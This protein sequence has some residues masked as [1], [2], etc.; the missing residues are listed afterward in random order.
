MTCKIKRIVLVL[1]LVAAIVP[2]VLL[3]VSGY[4]ETLR[5]VFMADSRGETLHDPVN[6]PVLNAIIGQIAALSPKPSFVIFGGDMSYRGYIGSSY[7]FQAWKDLFAPLTGSGVALYTAVGNHE[8]YHEHSALGFMLENQQEFQKVFSENPANGPAG[9]EHLAYSFTSPGGDSFFAVLDPYYL[10]SDVIPKTLGGNIDPTQMSWLTAQVAQTKATHKF[11]FIHTPYYYISNDPD[12]LSDANESFTGLWAFL[13]TNKFDFYACGHSHLFSRKTIDSTVPPNPQTTPPTPAWQNN[14]VQLLN[15]TSGAGPSTGTIDPNIKTSWNVH[16]D[17]K[18]YYFSVVDINGN[19]VSVTSYSGYTGDYTAFDSFTIVTAIPKFIISQDRGTIGT[20]FSITGSG[21][22]TRKGRVFVGT[23]SSK[24]VQWADDSIQ[25]QLTRTLPAGAYDVTIKPQTKG[26]S[27]ITISDGFTVEAPRIDSI[28]PP[29]GSIGDEITV[30]GLFFGMTKGG[31]TL[32][33]KSCR[34]SKWTMDSET[35]ESEI[36]F[37]V[38]RGLSTGTKELKVTNG[39][40]ADTAVI[41]VGASYT[42]GDWLIIDHPDGVG[43]FPR[44]VAGDRVVGY[45]E[46]AT[47]GDHGFVYDGKTWTDLDYPGA[48]DTVAS[49]ISGK[50]IVGFYHTDPAAQ[51]WHGFVYDGKNWTSLDYPGAVST[52]AFGIEGHTIVGYYWDGSAD[53]GFMYDGKTWTTLDHPGAQ[54]TFVSAV[55]HSTMVGDYVHN[56]WFHGYL[57][58]GVNWAALDAPGATDTYAHGIAGD[59]V[60]GSFW[61]ALSRT[62]G[63]LYNRA[64]ATWT[65]L[66]FPG[67]DDTDL[68]GTDGESIVGYIRVDEDWHGVLYTLAPDHAHHSAKGEG[69]VVGTTPA[70]GYGVILHTTNGGHRWG[71]QGSTNDVPNVS[72]NNVKAVNRHTVWVVGK[73]DSGYGVI[74]R[75]DDGGQSWVR[76]GQPGMI[77]DVEL[78]GVAAANRKTAWVVGTQGTIL[79]TDDEGRTWTQQQSGTTANLYEVTVVNSK[80]AWA[81]GDA[82]NGYAV[83]LHTTDG[84][85]TWE[86]QGTAATLGAHAFIDLTAANKR[87]AWAVGEDDFVAKTTDGGASWEIQMGKVGVMGPHN[88]GACAVDP[89]TAWIATDFSVVYRTINSGTTWEKQALDRQ[90]LRSFYLLGVSALDRNTA[91]VV[92]ENLPDPLVD[93]GIIL[94]TTDGGATW[95]V[96]TP[97]VDVPFRRVS[98]VGS[99]K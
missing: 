36:Q 66:D 40:G 83:I 31:V 53:H 15:G 57:Y 79:R 71:R 78:H 64:N 47:G 6:T 8:L 67:A 89:M 5:F 32:G 50:K 27:P 48:L 93:R 97:P 23:T 1:C 24:I 29:S 90:I 91:W 81:A 7:T 49:G 16:N 41:L 87:T 80:I 39:V 26:F 55:S 73:S 72:L 46:R 98:F 60:V 77:P 22:G 65:T 95:R 19:Q 35:G 56:D 44:A 10:T 52:R 74:L 59:L 82:D 9:Y 68:Y 18:T 17:A 75:T 4:C 84:G 85:Q 33:G 25:C 12:E 21:F 69:W 14:V 28:N 43:T 92:G 63:Y 3:P 11:L 51:V 86:R 34:V 62:H 58:D 2:V 45:Y 99:R 30:N 76:Q 96:Q 42:G 88:N 70:D 54:A 38:P 37:V 13:D 94:H 20:E 61:S